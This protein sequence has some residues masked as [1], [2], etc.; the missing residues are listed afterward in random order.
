MNIK[1]KKFNIL[2]PK[3]KITTG[4]KTITRESKGEKN[5][6]L[7]SSL[8]SYGTPPTIVGVAE[9]GDL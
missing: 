3:V 5:I 8:M 4:L 2:E 9:M 6:P 1:L 7:P